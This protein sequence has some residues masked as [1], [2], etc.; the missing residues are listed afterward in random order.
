MK[1]RMVLVIAAALIAVMCVCAFPGVAHAWKENGWE[2]SGGSWYYYENGSKVT[3]WYTIGDENYFFDTSSGKMRT[4]WI[5]YE[6][7]WFYCTSSGARA[8]GWQQIGG[9]WYYLDP[10]LGERMSADEWKIIGGN[11]YCFGVDGVMRTGWIEYK[12]R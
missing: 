9:K 12:E 8:G 4:G 7:Y 10:L 11:A 2:Y 5:E 3:G 6:G 1:R